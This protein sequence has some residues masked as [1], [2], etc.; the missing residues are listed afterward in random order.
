MQLQAQHTTPACSCTPASGAV[1]V[2]GTDLLFKSYTCTRVNSRAR[3]ATPCC[4]K[5]HKQYSGPKALGLGWQ[6]VVA[7]TTAFL[8]AGRWGLAPTGNRQATPG[9]KLEQ[10]NR[11]GVFTSDPAGVARHLLI[12]G[13]CSV[14]RLLEAASVCI[15]RQFKLLHTNASPT[16]AGSTSLP[17]RCSGDTGYAHSCATYC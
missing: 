15:C 9:L 4:R 5:V 11:G 16:I 14:C 8:A 3:T 7:S 10:T 17:C 6:I 13:Q 12:E 1:R 2:H